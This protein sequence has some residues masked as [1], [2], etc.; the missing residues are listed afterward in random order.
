MNYLDRFKLNFS[1]T[2]DKYLQS[3]TEKN[4]AIIEYAK[5]ESNALSGKQMAGGIPNSFYNSGDMTDAFSFPVNFAKTCKQMDNTSVCSNVLNYYQGMISSFNWKLTYK[6]EGLLQDVVHKEVLDVLVEQFDRMGGIDYFINHAVRDFMKYGLVFISPIIIAK[7]KKING[8]NKLLAYVDYF[9]ILDP[10]GI[11]AFYGDINNNDK[12]VALRYLS[13][14]K[15]LYN[16]ESGEVETNESFSKIIDFKKSLS[17]LCSLNTIGDPMGVSFLKDIWGSWRILNNM[18]MSFNANLISVGEHS[19]QFIPN[20]LF[21]DNHE[22][23]ISQV[24]TAINKFIQ[25]GG[26]FVSPYGH[27]EKITSMDLSKYDDWQKNISAEILRRKG[28]NVDNLGTSIGASANIA[29]FAQAEALMRAMNIAKQFAFQFS[30]GFIKNYV[31]NVFADLLFSKKIKDTPQL[32]F[33]TGEGTPETLVKEKEIELKKEENLSALEINDN[34]TVVQNKTKT[35]IKSKATDNESVVIDTSELDRVLLEVEN[36]FEEF[37]VKEMKTYLMDSDKIKKAIKDPN[38]VVNTRTLSREQEDSFYNG[39]NSILYSSIYSFFIEQANQY[40]RA[41]RVQGKDFIDVFKMGKDE[42][43]SHE[44][45]KLLRKKVIKDFKRTQLASFVNELDN[46]ITNERRY[47]SSVIEENETQG[48]IEL[49]ENLSNIKGQRFKALAPLSTM[50][51]FDSVNNYFVDKTKKDGMTLV[52]CGVLENQCSHCAEYM[53]AEYVYDGFH[54][55]GKMDYKQLP[56]SGCLGKDR[57]RCFYVKLPLKEINA[58][59]R[60]I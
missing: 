58:V 9:K 37:Y 50:L 4:N 39:L 10:Q 60:Y 14:S 23:A 8:K 34:A 33:E 46:T 53:G 6:D 30:E 51:I 59:S 48:Y 43:A 38:S 19:Y 56:D 41:L 22:N 36:K 28:M 29:Q 44:T 7:S 49:Q 26:V 13:Q 24:N 45:Q 55:V 27:L 42:F 2:Y 18:D 20:Q 15:A 31:E 16:T 25:G 47:L 21:F 5:Q 32:I 54:Y 3:E 35:W 11:L 52:R 12:I 57:C 17:C 40:E 1:T